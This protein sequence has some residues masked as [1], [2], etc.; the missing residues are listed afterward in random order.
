MLNKFKSGDKVIVLDQYFI[1][2]YEAKDLMHGEVIGK[3]VNCMGIT[4]YNIVLRD[5]DMV[6]H[7]SEDD[8]AID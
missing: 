4:G 1:D 3:H 8:L 7:V 2:K 6:I 5:F